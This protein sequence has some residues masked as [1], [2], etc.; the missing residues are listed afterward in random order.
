MLD[1]N[2][3]LHKLRIRASSLLKRID[4]RFVREK[5]STAIITIVERNATGKQIE[6]EFTNLLASDTWKWKARPVGDKKFIMRFPS[7]KLLCQ[8]CHFKFLPMECDDAQMKV[9]AWTPC[10]GAKGMLQQPWFKVHD[11]PT[12]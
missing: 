2:C 3:V 5:E 6:L 1:L 4:P 12:D 8:W 7:T 11:I 9:E 10:L